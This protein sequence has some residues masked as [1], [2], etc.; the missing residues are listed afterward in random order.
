MSSVP[1]WSSIKQTSRPRPTKAALR[2]EASAQIAIYSQ[3]LAMALVN[4]EELVQMCHRPEVP[5]RHMPE[6]VTG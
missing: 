1:D 5:K 4:S 2:S 6:M 3:E